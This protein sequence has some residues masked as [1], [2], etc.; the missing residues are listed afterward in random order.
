[1]TKLNPYLCSKRRYHA[2]IKGYLCPLVLFKT[3]LKVFN[4]NY[5]N[6]K[7]SIISDLVLFV[8]ERLLFSEKSSYSLG[9]VSGVMNSLQLSLSMSNIS[10]S[11]ELLL[12]NIVFLAK[13]DIVSV[14][15]T[16]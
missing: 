3:V 4:S 6:N 14:I 1:M 9:H 12:F 5:D 15:L 8:V 10:L 2:R 11:N 7:L 13:S 16:C